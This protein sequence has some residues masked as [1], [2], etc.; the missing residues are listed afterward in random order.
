MPTRAAATTLA[1]TLAEPKLGA[2]PPP[3]D[4]P[5]REHAPDVAGPW[6]L[7]TRDE[8]YDALH[9]R[10]PEPPRR[11]SAFER[12]AM[13]QA[14]A[15]DAAREAGDLPFRVRPGL[16]AEILRFYDQLRRQSQLVKR[17]EELIT[18]ALGGGDLDD[19]GADRLLRQ[20][21]FLARTFRGY[22]QRAAASDAVDEHQLRDQ[23]L[24]TP[25]AHPLAHVVVTVPD[26]IADPSGLFVA[27]FDLLNRLPNL[28]AIDIVSTDGALASGFHER[29][30]NWWPGL[31]E[32]TSRELL[33][34]TTRVRP[35]LMVPSPTAESAPLWFTYRDREEELL[36]VA[37]RLAASATASAVD[38]AGL[39]TADHA[40]APGP[41]PALRETAVSALDR[42][43]IVF[44][45][46]LPYL[47]LAADTLGAAG[48]PYVVADALPLAAE[49][50]VTAVDLVLDALEADFARDALVAMLRSPHFDLAHRLAR[51]TVGAL[52]RALSDARYLGG[53]DRLRAIAESWVLPSHEWRRRGA[54]PRQ[55]GRPALDAVLV[56]T[57]ELTRLA[58]PDRA[59]ILLQALTAFLESHLAPLDDAH[60]LFDRE[61]RARGALLQILRNLTNA[62]AAHHD[63]VWTVTDLAT[64]VRRWIGDET[65]ALA[66]TSA[67]V[68]LLDDQ[69]ARYGDFDDMTILG[70]IE[71]EWPDRTRRNIFYPPNLLKALGWP[72]E[73]DRRGAA[74]ARFLDL[75]ASPSARV[76]LSAFLLDDESIVSRSIQ[77]DE[78]PRA[79]L[80]TV[81]RPPLAAPL[82]ADEALATADEAPDDLA[83]PTR[84]WV[85]LRASRTPPADPAYH[86]SAGP[87]PDRTWSVS[88]LET[89]L[90]C[91][92]KFFAQHVLRLEEEPDD[93]EVMDPR[94]QGQFVHE[95]FEAFF[96]EW[97]NDG[98]RE[99]TPA[100]LPLARERFTAVVDR[101]L[102]RVPEGEAALER[103]R[104]LGSPAAAGLGEA[105]FRMEAER[106]VPVVA[107]LLEYKLD[108]PVTIQTASGPR[109]I[110]LRGK[111]DRLD[112]LADGTF[113]LIDYKLGWPPDRNRAL[114]LPIYAL[115]AEQQ[116]AALGRSWTLGEA[117]YLA[118]K[119]PRRVVP[120]FATDTARTE[121]LASAQQRMSDALDAIARG[122]FPPHPQD[123]FRCE[124]CSFSAVCRKDYVGDI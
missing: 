119:G 43:C 113:R 60:P 24:A 65:F 97:Q 78:V 117:V 74:D 20:T 73:K 124:T 96:T 21:H 9:A 91:P 6:M 53:A 59:S 61:R 4:E 77:L 90:T 49:P 12:D 79:R 1:R 30:H 29:L 103:T 116:L 118:F 102:D 5:P 27:D 115:C 64:T 63:P 88:A 36:A 25:A 122:E 17:F 62:H 99:I 55:A 11:L 52:D 26:W 83:G 32:L 8:L 114:Q 107:R 110:P 86:G 85:E 2:T 81:T 16:V 111:A 123:V 92:F 72:S 106:P 89:Y 39:F 38:D 42:S 37:R 70:L 19:R 18:E 47:Y 69:A 45:R 87:R 58:A 31:E 23:L 15:L 22:E 51:D 94:R 98:H 46:P 68:H 84:A 71:N 112:L 33:G 104:L 67:G 100:N 80:S 82:L 66:G 34:G 35:T 121:T 28:A 13:A 41:G 95:V 50:S 3:G 48:L 14:S 54:D 120:L 93:E 56:L 105:V 109:T 76:E 57:T 7:L 108:G 10:L 40:K 44:K 75:L 101:A